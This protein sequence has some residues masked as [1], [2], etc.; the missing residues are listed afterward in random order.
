MASRIIRRSGGK[1]ND[2]T[3]TT[4]DRINLCENYMQELS[5]K[6]AKKVKR[7]IREG[8]KI[9]QCHVRSDTQKEDSNTGWG[10]LLLGLELR[11]TKN[12][13]NC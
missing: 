3:W 2:L 8:R 11:D 12:S 13:E 10:L 9:C 7:R 1:W 6:D 4:C 5:V